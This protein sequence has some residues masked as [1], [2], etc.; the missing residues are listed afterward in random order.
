MTQ[1]IVHVMECFVGGARRHLMDL[2][3][4][5]AARGWDV[6]AILSMERDANARDHAAE[7]ARQGVRVHE[8]AMRRSVRPFADRNIYRELR[9][10]LSRLDPDCVH[11]HGSKAGT[12]GRSAARAVGVAGVVHTPHGFAFEKRAEFGALHRFVFRAVERSMARITHA[13]VVLSEREREVAHRC[14]I[15]RR[16][17]PYL[18]PNAVDWPPECLLRTRAEARRRL[19]VPADAWMLFH[20][21]PLMPEKGQADLLKALSV[22]KGPWRLWMAGAGPSRDVLERT[23]HQLGLEDRV[24]FLGWRDDVPDWIDACDLAVLPSRSEAAPYFALEV[25]VRHRPLLATRVSGVEE[26]IASGRNGWLVAPGDVEGL[27]RGLL[28][29]SQDLERL[30]AMGAA[31]RK[32]LRPEH[33]LEAMI[34]AYEEL[35]AAMAARR[36][37]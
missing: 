6:H 2:S 29:A 36:E 23:S 37:A 34:S 19:G 32:S 1:R 12:L 33:R 21:G 20:A 31:A 18:I 30:H 16:C 35:Y 25:L 26:C 5:L 15:A 27:A 14:G 11:T 3:R 28:E 9:N 8:L 7:L 17:Q 4:E 10:M 13:L 24:V 22:A